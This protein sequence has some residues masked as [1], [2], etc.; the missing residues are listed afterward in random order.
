MTVTLNS[1][2]KMNFQRSATSTLSIIFFSRGSLP[3][4]IP[5]FPFPIDTQRNSMI[6]DSEKSFNT[7]IFVGRRY[8]RYIPSILVGVVYQ[9]LWGSAHWSAPSLTH[10]HWFRTKIILFGGHFLLHKIML[11]RLGV[12]LVFLMKFFNLNHLD[13]FFCRLKRKKKEKKINFYVQLR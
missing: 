7:K 3:G 11:T 13:T 6:E 10:Q 9:Q 1:E 8:P 12:P 4:L 2:K 5:F